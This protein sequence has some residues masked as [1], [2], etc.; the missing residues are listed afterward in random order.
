MI[1]IDEEPL[2]A[3]DNRRDPHPSSLVRDYS[4]SSKDRPTITQT[5][6][7]VTTT[8]EHEPPPQDTDNNYLQTATS[9]WSGTSTTTG[10]PKKIVGFALKQAKLKYLCE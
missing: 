6:T 7:N 5:P 9:S 2:P 4:I 10:N 8:T 1:R 3:S